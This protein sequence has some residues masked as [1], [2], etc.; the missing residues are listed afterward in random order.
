MPTDTASAKAVASVLQTTPLPL[1]A[2]NYAVAD[3]LKQMNVPNFATTAPTLTVFI[4]VSFFIHLIRK[5][6]KQ[7]KLFD[8]K[9]VFRQRLISEKKSDK[10]KSLFAYLII[11]LFAFQAFTR[12]MKHL[13]SNLVAIVRSAEDEKLTSRLVNKLKQKNIFISELIYPET[14]NFEQI[15][16]DSDSQIIL[17]FLSKKEVNFV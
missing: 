13:N 10:A 9:N 3:E 17:T 12:L 11:V 16:R 5:N 6:F 2:Y 8:R 15:I 7:K 1:L 14:P 4:D